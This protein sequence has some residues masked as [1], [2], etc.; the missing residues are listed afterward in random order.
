MKKTAKAKAIIK[1]LKQ[2]YSPKEITQRMDASYNYAWTLQKKLAAEK[3]AAKAAKTTILSVDSGIS[4]TPEEV[5]ISE[6]VFMEAAHQASQGKDKIEPKHEPE[7]SV[8]D[9]V[10]DAR[11]DQYG[12]FMQGADIA[13]R[14][15]GIMHNAIARKDM[16]LYPD[17]LL[18]LDMIAVKISRIVN[19]NASHRDS[20]LDIAGYAKLVAD[21]LGGISR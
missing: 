11:A 2:G 3:A 5:G 1:L 16:H 14:I 6:E 17:Q 10:L 8:V 15:K 21:R 18:A 9:K 13:V 12:S 19:G 20:W 4:F 7:V